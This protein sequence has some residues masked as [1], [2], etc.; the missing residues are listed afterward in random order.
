MYLFPTTQPNNQHPK[1]S[2][3][4]KVDIVC[5]LLRAGANPTISSRKSGTAR[6]IAERAGREEIVLVLDRHECRRLLTSSG[7]RERR[8]AGV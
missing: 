6:E 7:L 4:G 3:R 1:H 2:Q 8:L 5:T